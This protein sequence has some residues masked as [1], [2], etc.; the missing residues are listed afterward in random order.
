MI[1]IVIELCMELRD[2]Y[3][4]FEDLFLEFKEEGMATVFLE[5]LK[6]FILAGFF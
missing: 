1:R 3:F 4:L 5:E 6:P 2:A